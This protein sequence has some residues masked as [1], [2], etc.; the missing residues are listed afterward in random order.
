VDAPLNQAKSLQ[1]L[2]AKMFNTNNDQSQ[3]I[4]CLTNFQ[5]SLQVSKQIADE[6]ISHIKMIKF[7]KKL[8]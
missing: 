7:C 5:N 2:V 6:A 3:W 4:N 1:I 8:D